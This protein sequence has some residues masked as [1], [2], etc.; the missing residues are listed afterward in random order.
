MLARNAAVLQ[1]N[2]FI[3]AEQAGAAARFDAPQPD[4]TASNAQVEIAFQI[5]FEGGDPTRVRIRLALLDPDGHEIA[6]QEWDKSDVKPGERCTW[7][8]RLDTRLPPGRYELV[9]LVN[10]EKR[11]SCGIRVDPAA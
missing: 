7:R 10:G 5:A 2:G 8:G 11:G 6:P 1:Q 3:D 9:L 4:S